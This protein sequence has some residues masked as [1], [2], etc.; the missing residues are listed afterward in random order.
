M[1]MTILERAWLSLVVDFRDKPCVVIGGGPVAARKLRRLV[2][3]GARITLV[4][5]R[6]APAMAALLE[7]SDIVFYQR[8]FQRDDLDGAQLIIAAT[9][10]AAVNASIAGDALAR[11]IPVNVATPGALSTALLPQ[12]IHRAPLQITIAGGGASPALTRHLSRQLEAIIPHA[13]GELAA[14]LA[15]Y[16]DDIRAHFPDALERRRFY[17]AI[18]EGPVAEQVF[19]GDMARARQ[20]MNDALSEACIPLQIVPSVAANTTSDFTKSHFGDD[21]RD[22]LYR[23]IS[24][25]RDMRHFIAGTCIDN[26]TL[27]RLLGATH[28]APSVGL[29]QPWRFIRITDTTLRARIAAHVAEERAVT[30]AALGERAAEFLR[31]KVEGIS[32]CAELLVVALAPDDGSVF[33]RRTMPDDMAM[34][35]AACAIQNLWLAARAENLGMGWVSMFDPATLAALLRMPEGAKPIAILCLGPVQSFYPQPMLTAERW[36]SERP[37]QEFVFHDS[38]GEDSASH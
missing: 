15:E 38:W 4:A 35:S 23:I 19:A 2:M 36:R 28:Q 24:A 1:N 5:P 16:R 26:A 6:L 9:D 13:Y 29:M 20:T 37:L 10:D 34:C 18:I 14:L 17:D 3:A 32:E 8:N 33:G 27:A 21:E 22:S 7:G 30:A 25:R 11:G 31:L 12:P